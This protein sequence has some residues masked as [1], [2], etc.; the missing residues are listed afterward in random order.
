[1][2]EARQIQWQ[3]IG[4]DVLAQFDIYAEYNNW[5]DKDK[6]A[7]LKCCLTGIAGQLSWDSGQPETLTFSELSE[8]LR[9]RFG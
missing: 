5:T 9:R 3:W 4:G 6:A 1:M 8:K 7:H 2:D